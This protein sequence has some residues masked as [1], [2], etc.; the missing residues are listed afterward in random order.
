MAASITA[1]SAASVSSYFITYLHLY[2]N[3]KEREY[4]T[5]NFIV[6]WKLLKKKRQ[7]TGGKGRKC[8]TREMKCV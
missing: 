5:I 7:R 2:T 1:P 6:S 4:K 3:F 8:R